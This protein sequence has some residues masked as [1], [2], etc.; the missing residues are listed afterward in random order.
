MVWY[1]TLYRASKSYFWLISKK[2][3]DEVYSTPNTVYLINSQGLVAEH[4]KYRLRNR[5]IA[6]SIPVQG[7]FSTPFS[8]DFNLAVLTM[9]AIIIVHTWG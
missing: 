3:C 2:E 5:N 7:H 6:G 1:R 9:T 8:K 4:M